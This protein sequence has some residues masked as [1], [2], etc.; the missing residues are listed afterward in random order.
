MESL[1]KDDD[2][3]MIKVVLQGEKEKLSINAMI[4]SGA[5]EDFIDKEVY[6]KHQI[7]TIATENPRE[8]YL[9]DGNP[10]GMGPVTH[11][12]RVPMTIGNHQEVATLQV[13]N[14]QNHEVILGMPWLK[15]HNPKIDWEKNKITFDSKRCTTWCLDRKSIVYAIPETT[16]REE[17]L[18]A[19][20][21]EIYSQQRGLL[22][23]KI[24]L[25]ARIPTKGSQRAAGHDLYA[26]E[27]KIIPAK[28]QAI[29]GTGIAV[30][31][32]P[33]T[34]G[35]IAPRS[36]LA[37]KHAL[38]IN[39]GVIDADYTGEV[40]VILAN[41]SDQDYEVHK[42]DKIAQLIVEIILSEEIVLAQDLE[43]TKRGTKGF[44]SSDKELTK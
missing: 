16:A 38:A 25:E 12:A 37:A 44:G 30:G 17:N 15:G 34:Y 23:K 32:P 10:S 14:L 19:R 8:I 35:R 9:A 2:H 20:F 13:A 28:G 1:E 3:I 24:T 11:I 22:V 42:G 27:A 4:D 29:I 18:I 26:K 31:L 7:S 33:G 43:D 6:Q 36:G 39:A 5:T 41:L 21:S 40:K